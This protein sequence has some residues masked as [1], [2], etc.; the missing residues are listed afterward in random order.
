[1]PHTLRRVGT[2][3]ETLAELTVLAGY[4]DDLAAQAT[5]LTNRPRDA[6]LHI[7]PALERLVGPRLDRGGVLDLLAAAPPPVTRRSGSSIKGETRSQRG[8]HALKSALFLSA[9]ASLSDPTSRAY[10]D[11]K[12]TERSATTPPSSASLDAASTSSTPYSATASPTNS[13]PLR[14]PSPA[15]SRLDKFIVTPP[16]VKSPGSR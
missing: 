2:D 5:R 14:N 6:L 8:N 1:M 11:R 15:L 3:D 7:H 9:F 16:P 4:D 12:K 13:R 10:Y